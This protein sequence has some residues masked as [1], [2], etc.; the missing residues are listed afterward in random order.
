LKLDIVPVELTFAKNSAEA[1]PWASRFH[2]ILEGLG[3]APVDGAVAIQL[4]PPKLT[5]SPGLYK[6]TP[7][8]GPRQLMPSAALANSCHAELFAAGAELLFPVTAIQLDPAY[9]TASPELYAM[10]D[11][12][13]PRQ[14]IPGEPT[15]AIC[16]QKMLDVD[17]VT[18]TLAPRASQL[19]PL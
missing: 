12:Q 16:V 6:A 7:D 3:V 18:L 10:F 8:Q 9:E 13:G 11:A 19:E 2:A 1:L 14:T 15:R 4:D 17:G 5:A